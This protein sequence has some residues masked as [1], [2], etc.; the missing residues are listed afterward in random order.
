MWLQGLKT[1]FKN[2]EKMFRFSSNFQ[3]MFMNDAPNFST[4]EVTIKIY[5]CLVISNES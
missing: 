5:R 4:S 3:E 2:A 1:I